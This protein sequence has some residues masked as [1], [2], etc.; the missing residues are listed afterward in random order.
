MADL[1][2]PFRKAAWSAGRVIVPH[3]QTGAVLRLGTIGTIV[4]AGVI[5]I[6][7]VAP[8]TTP[9]DGQDARITSYEQQIDQLS[10][11]YANTVEKT[12]EAWR[13]SSIEGKE[14]AQV[15]MDAAHAE[16]QN[17]ATQV[18]AGIYTETGMSEDAAA[19]LLDKF[20]NSIGDVSTIEFNGQKFADIGDAAFLRE[21]QA[22]YTYQG[23]EMDRAM[24]IS[25]SA[26]AQ[27]EGEASFKF[28]S[29][30]F[31]LMG[32]MVSVLL[33]LLGEITTNGGMSRLSK[34]LSGPPPKPKKSSG[35]NH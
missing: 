7:N 10:G 9:V 12:R 16:F 5:G 28:M 17:T 21:A 24:K 2:Y 35:F 31:G 4:A 15:E 6:T 19:D 26:A 20:E 1:S 34:R 14:A 8:D 30:L 33:I 18:L 11:F 25:Q 23:D 3:S 32:G 13:S 29:P 27:N 22:D